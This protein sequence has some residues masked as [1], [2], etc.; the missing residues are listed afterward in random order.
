VRD[1]VRIF[2]LHARKGERCK[3]SGR[4]DIQG[5]GLL[6]S[7]RPDTDDHYEHDDIGDEFHGSPL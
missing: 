3:S 7:H 6:R 2:L 4:S 1:L 5:R